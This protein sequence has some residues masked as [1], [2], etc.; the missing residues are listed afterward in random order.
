[1]T[2]TYE[3]IPF[4]E[5]QIVTVRDERGV[6]VVMKPVVETIGVNWN[7]QYQRIKRHPVLSEGMCVTHIPSVGG[8]QE[9]V[10]LELECFH[11]WLVTISPDRIA[12]ESKRAVI[13]DYQRRAFR[14]IYEHYHGRMG[15]G[16]NPQTARLDLSER[17]EAKKGI[18]RYA[19]LLLRETNPVLRQ[20]YHELLAQDCATVGVSV[21]A[22]GQLGR[23][24][25]TPPDMLQD[26]WSAVRVVRDR[27]VDFDHSRRSDLLAISL[28]EMDQHFSDAGIRIKINRPLHSALRL[29]ADPA[30]VEV[31][32]VNSRKTQGAR[33]CW[34]FR[35]PL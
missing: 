1:M 32:T 14:V 4:N 22:L 2:A 35:Q 17:I 29:S 20:T 26:F 18:E 11:G 24:A 21:P 23:A 30:F 7:G 8:M 9:A 25:P 15:Q 28:K 16:N 19:Q 34:V 12:D 10:T 13:I 33:R 3:I 5:H 6:H 31:T 27:G